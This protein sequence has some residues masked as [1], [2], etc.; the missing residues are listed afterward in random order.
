MDKIVSLC[1]RRGFLFQS[2]E[3]YGGVQGFWDYGPL[4]VELKRN[5][6]DAWWSDMISAHNELIVP[7]N[8][9]SEFEMVG[10]D[11]TIIMHPQVW[12]CSGHYDLFHD[13]MVDCRESKKRYRFDQVRGRWCSHGEKKIFVTTMAEAELELDEVRRRAMKFFKLRPKNADELSVGNES[14][15][16]DQIQERDQVLAPDAKSL[17]TLTEPREFN[18]MFKTTLGALGGEEDAA[19]LR[20]E[21][22]Q[23]IFVNFKNVVDTSRVKIPFGIGQVGKSFRNEI[24]PRNFTFRSR[25][26]E[27]MEIEFFCHPEQSK[28]WYQYWRDRRMNWYTSMGLSSESLIMREHH[29]EELAHYSIGTADIEYAFPFLPAG[30]YG[31]LEGIAHRGDFDL[32]SHMEG[33]LDPNSPEGQ[34]MQV[35]LN[36]NGKPKHKGSGKDLSYRDPVT[37]ERFVPHVI[38]PSA[39]ADRAALAFI[40]EAY[41]EDKVADD[42]G[43]L[44]ERTVMKLNPRLAPIKAAIFPLVKKDGMPE[45]AKEMYSELKKHM[46]VYYDDKGAVGKRYRRQDE[47]GTP[48]CIT[49]DTDTLSDNTVTIRDRDSLEQVRVKIDDLV[50]ELNQRLR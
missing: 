41:S 32:R 43:D 36:E 4:G 40:C 50:G 29:Q 37:N 49:V 6:K 14:L 27:Q 24:T 47:V 21:T 28:Q 16:L 5:L 34:P 19:F 11:C 20:P 22:A 3:I 15:T 30:E 39:G 31:E 18:L 13:H 8:A 45:I 44:Q 48:Y 23:G 1:K 42:K 25:E 2:S 9:P 10:L 38:E 17:D 7:A 46:N 35:E 33:K 26:F 12:K